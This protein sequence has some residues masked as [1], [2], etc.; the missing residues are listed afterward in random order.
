V[1][2]AFAPPQMPIWIDF[3]DQVYGLP[4][5]ESRGFKVGPDRHGPAFDPDTGERIVSADGIATAR[6]FSRSA[7]PRWRMHRSWRLASA[8]T[9]TRRAATS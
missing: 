7:F 1:I 5:L 4:D 8:S 2:A 6:S 9:R 3:G